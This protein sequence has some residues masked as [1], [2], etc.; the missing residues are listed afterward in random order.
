LAADARAQDRPR[1]QFV[2][3]SVDQLNTQPLR[4]GEHPL[5]DL[6]GRSLVQGQRE[7]FDYRSEDGET[8]VDVLEFRRRARGAGATVY[9]FGMTVGPALA[10]R[11]SYEEL[12]VIRFT[13]T[14]PADVHEYALVDGRAYD[15]GVGVV[16]SDRSPGWGLGSHAFVAAGA[17]R[18][19]SGLGDGDRYFAEGGGG[20]TVGPVGVQLAVKVARNRLTAPREHT[21]FTVPISLR[22]T[23]SF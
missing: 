21:F 19:R 18:I 8:L 22:G 23:L 6:I 3:I 17:G 5:E 4:F 14:G 16:V 7:A 9:P 15:V 2:T 1:R 10:V 11:G 13:A 12:P 20:L